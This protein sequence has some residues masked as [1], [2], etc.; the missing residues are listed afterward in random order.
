MLQG[1][2]PVVWERNP[3][4]ARP[5]DDSYPVV[6]PEDDPRRDYRSIYDVSGDPTLLDTLIARLTRG[7]EVVLAGFYEQALSF[8][9]P[10]A[11]MREARIRI[12][13][14]WR[15]S[16]LEAVK[17]LAELGALSLDGLIT[18]RQEAA[19]AAAAYQTAFDDPLCLK[20]ILDWRACS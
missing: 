7:G 16:D 18:H 1:A 10:A 17:S 4:R 9:F 11:F 8:A 5:F 15:Q 14:E 2:A 13:A 3:E 12:A 6:R 19:Q 20:M